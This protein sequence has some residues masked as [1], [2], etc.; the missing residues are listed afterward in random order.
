MNEINELKDRIIKGNKETK[1]TALTDIFNMV[2]EFG[3]WGDLLGREF[4][5]RTVKGEMIYSITQKPLKLSQ[6]HSLMK[7]FEILKKIDH[8]IEAKKLGGKENK[9][10]S[11]LKKR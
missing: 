4:E 3:S 7:E 1:K 11:P 2:R 5:V 6:L 10:F 9:G 8:E